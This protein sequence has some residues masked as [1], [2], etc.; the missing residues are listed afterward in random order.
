MLSEKLTK[1]INRQINREIYSG[2]FYLGMAS[3]AANCGLNGVANWFRKQF[4]EELEHADRMFD[5][6]N[7]RGS[8]VVLEAIE[9]P[10][11]DFKSAA[12]L[13]ERTVAHEKAVTGLINDLVK[14]AKEEGDK[15]TED[16]LQWFVK[17]QVEE[18]RTPAI[19]LGKVKPVEKDC[20]ALNAV[21][22]ELGLRK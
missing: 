3:Y 5:Y 7:K 6:V 14:L 2:Y 20:E 15:E 12:D 4:G 9:T 17:E 8:K 1:A 13:F 16:F 18:E 19:W 11:Q 21:D 10:P 22:A